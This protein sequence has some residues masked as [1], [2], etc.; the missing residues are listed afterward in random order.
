MVAPSSDPRP[1]RVEMHS[2]AEGKKTILQYSKIE[3]APELKAEAFT[4]DALQ[5]SASPR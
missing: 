1:F 2:R 4:A 3:L 5:R